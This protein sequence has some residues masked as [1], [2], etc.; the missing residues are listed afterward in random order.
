[1]PP[2]DAA[3]ADPVTISAS[4]PDPPSGAHKAPDGFRF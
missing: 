4:Q 3:G 2:A 1:M